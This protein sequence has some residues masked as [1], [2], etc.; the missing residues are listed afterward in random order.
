M[1]VIS[2]Y[3]KFRV[4]LERLWRFTK[5]DNRDY[6]SLSLIEFSSRLSVIFYKLTRLASGGRKYL[7]LKE[8]NSLFVKSS[9]IF[10]R[11]RRLLNTF[12]KDFS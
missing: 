9:E 3:F 10:D 4:R 1:C 2:F 12:N 6:A 5:G 8:N 11:L 7:A